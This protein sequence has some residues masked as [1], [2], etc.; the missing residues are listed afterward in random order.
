MGPR[1]VRII[2]RAAAKDATGYRRRGRVMADSPG[3][4][5]LTIDCPQTGLSEPVY[6]SNTHDED[7]VRRCHHLVVG[8]ASEA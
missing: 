1:V 4:L 6:P 2:S 7:V 5:N 3:T 8:H